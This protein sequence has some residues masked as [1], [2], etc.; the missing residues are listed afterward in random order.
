MTIKHV[1]IKD[2]QVFKDEFV[3]E[4]YSGVNVLI[5]ANATGKTTLIKWLYFNKKDKSNN[6]VFIPEKDILEH[7][8]GLFTFIEKKQTGFGQIYKDVLINAQDT[9]TIEQS[10]I[11]KTICKIIADTI[12]GEVHYDKGEGTF[13]TLKTGG[14]RIPFANEASGYKKL[15]FLGLLVTS[16]QLENGS[17]LFW[18]EP[19]NSLNPELVPVLVDI[20][21]QLS[22]SG[23]QIFIATHDYNFARYFDVKKNGDVMFYNLAKENDGRIT[24]CSSPEYTKLSENLLETAGVDLYKAVVKYAMEVDDDE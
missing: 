12:D 21:L 13:Y 22:Q 4:F 7:S 20:L 1:A 3:V 11:Q 16:G 10:K 6:F 18:D 8:K 14:K 9:P 19:E 2:F 17:V 15:G 23:V 5:G 24:V